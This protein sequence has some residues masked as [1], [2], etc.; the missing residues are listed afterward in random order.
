MAPPSVLLRMLNDDPR[1]IMS[2]NENSFDI[3]CKPRTETPLLSAL[4]V[5]T[6]ILDPMFMNWN[7]DSFPADLTKLRTLRLL[8]S[9]IL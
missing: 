9:V 8:P 7:K 6:E 2:I 5:R 1:F 4:I 3:R